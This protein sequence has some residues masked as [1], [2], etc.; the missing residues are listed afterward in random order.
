[1]RSTVIKISFRSVCKSKVSRGIIVARSE[2]MSVPGVFLFIRVFGRSPE[3][4]PAGGD[5]GVGLCRGSVLEIA[6][7]D[8]R[9]RFLRSRPFYPY[10]GER[11]GGVRR[12]RR[13][14]DKFKVPS[15][16]HKSRFEML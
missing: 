2:D 3:D 5:L 14:Q 16:G 12:G 9:D 7:S 4:P 15:H 10:R 1:M 11:G 6:G 8:A 13:G